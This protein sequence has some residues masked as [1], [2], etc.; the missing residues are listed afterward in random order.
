MMA[1]EWEKCWI[2]CISHCTGESTGHS[3]LLLWLPMRIDREEIE[4]KLLMN[5]CITKVLGFKP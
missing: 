3:F 2:K 4:D 5:D 1:C